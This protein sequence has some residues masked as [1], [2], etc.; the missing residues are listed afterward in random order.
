MERVTTTVDGP[1]SRRERNKAEKQGRILAAA[2]SLFATKPFDE[3]TT[4][5]VAET[6]DVATGTLFNYA[7]SKAELLMW[8][9]NDFTEEVLIGRIADSVAG[10]TDSDAAVDHICALLEPIVEV[11]TRRPE[12]FAAYTRE[13]LFGPPGPHRSEALDV[14]AALETRIGEI[15]VADPHRQLRQGL[16]PREAGRLVW[17]SMCMELLGMSLG[18]RCT[19][20]QRAVLRDYVDSLVHGMLV[21]P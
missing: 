6:A 1:V 20:D 7:T 15:L 16:T 4:Q 3:V 19:R 5:E 2:R 13:S 21:G 17:S 12:N 10:L 9:A 18:H 8:V 14:L 11:A